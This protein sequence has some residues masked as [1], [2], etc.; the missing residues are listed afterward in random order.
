MGI[1]TRKNV[2]YAFLI[3]IM[4][5]GIYLIF[6]RACYETNDEMAFSFFLGGGYGKKSVYLIYS[7]IFYGYFLSPFYSYIPGINWY[8]IFQYVF[9]FISFFVLSSIFLIKTEKYNKRLLRCLAAFSFLMIFAYQHYYWIQYTKS[10]YLIVLAGMILVFYTLHDLNQ[11]KRFLFCG[12][13]LILFGSFVRFDSALVI[14]AFAFMRCIYDLIIEQKLEFDY[15]FIE[16]NFK[17]IATFSLILFLLF[18]FE[19]SDKL[20]YKYGTESQKWNDYIEYNDLRT[21]LLDFGIPDYEEYEQQ[22]KKIGLSENDIKMLSSWCFS[23]PETFNIETFKQIIDIKESP[24]WSFTEIYDNLIKG[25]QNAIGMAAIVL[26]V[27][28]L[29]NGKKKH[30]ILFLMYAVIVFM[31]YGYLTYKGRVIIRAEY[32]IWLCL[33]VFLLYDYPRNTTPIKEK[34]VSVSWMVISIAI[35]LNYIND[36]NA[37]QHEY[38]APLQTEYRDVYDYMNSHK[39]NVYMRDTLSLCMWYTGF[40]IY[41]TLPKDYLSNVCL[42]GGWEINHPI[43]NVEEQYGISNPWR[44]CVDSEKIYI[45]DSTGIDSKLEFIRQRYCTTARAIQTDEI[46]G[47]KVYKIVSE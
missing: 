6:F 4:V 7:N 17:Y 28:F 5:L 24:E 42:M 13:L 25:T 2:L 47:F 38:T 37:K 31:L 45:I 26:S 18:G 20:I 33:C 44:E 21:E 16:K 40:S 41:E 10:A 9:N 46:H 23:D 14:L 34:I 15:R 8:T 32:G 30:R 29:L 11:S 12:I 35:L 3:N 43:V 27:L 39:E 22:Y 1:T 36:Y 19:I